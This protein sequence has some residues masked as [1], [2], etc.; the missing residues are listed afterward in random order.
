MHSRL[1]LLLLALRANRE[2]ACN[3]SKAQWPTMKLSAGSCY[4]AQQPAAGLQATLCMSHL[5]LR[6]AARSDQPSQ[7]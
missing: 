1:H 5:E 3:C 7:A 6:L 2:R 4:I